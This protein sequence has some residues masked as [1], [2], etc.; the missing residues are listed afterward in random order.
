MIDY[1]SN[2]KRVKGNQKAGELAYLD[3]NIPSLA[4]R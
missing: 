2:H 4:N 1:A 3:T